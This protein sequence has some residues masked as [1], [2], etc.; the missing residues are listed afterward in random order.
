MINLERMT[1]LITAYV[2]ET[3]NA[4]V[5]DVEQIQGSVA[6]LDFGVQLSE[7]RRLMIKIGPAGELSAEA[8]ACRRLVAK[9]IPVPTVAWLDVDHGIDGQPT[10]IMAWVPGAPSEEPAVAREAGRWFRWVHSE[11]L[12]GWGPLVVDGS[13]LPTTARGRY[14]TWT[15]AVLADLSGID[16]LVRAGVLSEDLAR[17]AREAVSVAEIVDFAGPGVLLHN[18]LK[19]AHLFGVDGEEGATLSSIIDW[20]DARVGDPLA[21]LARCSMSGPGITEAFLAGYGLEPTADLERQ[22]ARYRILWNVAALTYEYRAG[23]DWFDVYRQ[24]IIDELDRLRP[25]A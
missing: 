20:G 1:K 17:S 24:R 25:R 5:I 16:D 13:Q 15:D 2:A 23:G 19:P 8:W 7:G 9:G 6:N 10:L 4:A 3:V 18:D 12:P 22:L 21:D 11:V 14:D